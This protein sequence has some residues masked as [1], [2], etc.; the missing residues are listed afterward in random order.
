MAIERI[1]RDPKIMLGKPCVAGTR[2]TVEAI[3]EDLSDGMSVAQVLEAY[4]GLTEEDVRAAL[5]YAAR[6]LREEGLVAA[7]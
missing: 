3:L 7:E 5:D 6:Y 4:E 1:T 2:I